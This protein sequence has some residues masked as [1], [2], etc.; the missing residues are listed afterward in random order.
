M[1][2]VALMTL[3]DAEWLGV[4]RAQA[5][6]PGVTKQAIA[7]ELGISRTAV[8]LLIAGKYTAGTTKVERKIA[9]KV[10][11][12][13]AHRVWC[14]HLHASITPD[15]CRAF[16]TAPMT[17]SDPAGLRHWVACQK[18]PEKSVREKEGGDAV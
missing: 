9:N 6:K 3:P 4:L 8:S 18:C 10:M 16:C 1:R 2:Q 17:M 14:P 7:D 5:E 13:Y 11:A 15:Q 12:L